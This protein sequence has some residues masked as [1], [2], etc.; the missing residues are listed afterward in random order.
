[1]TLPVIIA[2]DTSGGFCAAVIHTGKIVKSRCE[3]MN[4][5]QAESLM[6][7]LNQL[8][9]DQGL[10][11]SD[12]DGVG[13]GIGPGNFTG[14]RISVSAARGLA[15]G[16]NI[17]SVGVSSLE[18]IAWG[19]SDLR[20]AVMD[21]YQ[22]KI[23]AQLFDKSQTTL[24]NCCDLT[25]TSLDEI[26]NGMNPIVMGPASEKVASLMGWAIAKPKTTQINAILQITRIRIHQK[27]KKPTPLYLRQPDA[28]PNLK[29]RPAILS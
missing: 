23:Y 19:R 10:C 7:M 26:A 4:R 22:N 17:P 25:E 8:L 20:L 9:R 27:N 6:P 21:A 28:K 2:F 13:V 1:M 18:A 24:P 15:F 16:L 11:F 29:E 14:V 3:K 12:I 5:G